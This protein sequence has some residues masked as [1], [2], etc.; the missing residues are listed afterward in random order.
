MAV[1][2]SVTAP[3]GTPLK[4][5]KISIIVRLCTVFSKILL[6]SWQSLM[7]SVDCWEEL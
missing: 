3:D 6:A 1:A 7:L 5:H 4:D 2:G